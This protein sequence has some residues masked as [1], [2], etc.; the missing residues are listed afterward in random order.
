MQKNSDICVLAL[1]TKAEFAH[2]KD[3]KTD[4][5]RINFKTMDAYGMGYDSMTMYGE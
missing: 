2:K 3:L 4:C 1:G 5:D